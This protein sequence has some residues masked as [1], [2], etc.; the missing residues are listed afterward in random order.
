MISTLCFT[1]NIKPVIQWDYCTILF[2]LFWNTIIIPFFGPL[3][4]RSDWEQVENLFICISEVLGSD[5]LKQHQEFRCNKKIE[6]MELINLFS[7]IRKCVMYFFSVYKSSCYYL[8]S[9]TCNF[10]KPLYAAKLT[11]SSTLTGTIPVST[12]H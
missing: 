4:W 11:R 3:M 5:L 12:T 10:I 1:V 7:M 9:I 8:L 2:P 6:W